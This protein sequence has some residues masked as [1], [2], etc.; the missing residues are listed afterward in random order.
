MSLDNMTIES[1]PSVLDIGNLI[2]P[3]L[4]KIFL[5]VFLVAVVFAVV[6]AAVF[7]YHWWRYAD[8]TPFALA[9]AASYAVGAVIFLGIM[10]STL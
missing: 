8:N 5:G 3:Y 6:T 7:L 2:L 9:T 10:A 1:P 4:D